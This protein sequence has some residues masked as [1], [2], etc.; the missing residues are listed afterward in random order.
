MLMPS[1]PPP[2]APIAGN[3]GFESDTELASRSPRPASNRA[4]PAAQPH[5]VTG[6]GSAQGSLKGRIL[7]TF[8]LPGPG[9]EAGAQP[10]II[11]TTTKP[12]R[13]R[14]KKTDAE[15]QQAEAEKNKDAADKEGTGS[16]QKKKTRRRR[17]PLQ[18]GSD[19]KEAHHQTSGAKTPWKRVKRD[20]PAPKSKANAKRSP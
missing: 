10:K 12:R 5:K 14:V 2:Q 15:K 17:R 9:E 11:R 3:G 7:I 13:K 1:S 16:E 18:E 19:K 4:E 8:K 20:S 6:Y